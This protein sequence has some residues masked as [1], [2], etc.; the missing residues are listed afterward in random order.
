MRGI[1]V[2]KDGLRQRCREDVTLL[3]VTDILAATKVD[4]R[5]QCGEYRGGY[6]RRRDGCSNRFQV[7]VNLFRLAADDARDMVV[8]TGIHAEL[9][10]EAVAIALD[11]GGLAVG[12]HIQAVGFGVFAPRQQVVALRV[13]VE[14]G[15]HGVHGQ[16]LC[17][18]RANFVQ[19]EVHPQRIVMGKQARVQIGGVR[20]V[21]PL[22][23]G[24]AHCRAR[25]HHHAVVV[26]VCDGI[27]SPPFGSQL[28]ALEIVTAHI[29]LHE[30]TLVVGV[31]GV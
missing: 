26:D 3:N 6:R 24:E 1:F 18:R 14:V 17:L 23:L 12:Q 21:Q 29:S 7:D 9:G 28:D 16:T 11:G 27:H 22:V 20:R 8:G 13:V 15:P 5:C 4:G 10:Q 31:E 2:V 25:H 30:V 19:I